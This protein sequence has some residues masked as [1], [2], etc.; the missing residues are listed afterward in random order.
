MSRTELLFLNSIFY[1]YIE[2]AAISKIRTDA[3]GAV[4]D[5][6]NES[7]YASHASPVDDMLQKGF[8]GYWKHDLGPI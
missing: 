3:F 1:F 7:A 8:T 2:G 4:A 6:Y 5:Y